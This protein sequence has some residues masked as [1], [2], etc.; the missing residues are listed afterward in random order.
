VALA[1]NIKNAIRIENVNLDQPLRKGKYFLR[2]PLTKIIAYT[3]TQIKENVREVLLKHI[4]SKE[5]EV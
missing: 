4:L 1:R 2:R 5:M 3:L